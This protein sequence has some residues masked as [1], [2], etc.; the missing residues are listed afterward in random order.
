M[1][2]GAIVQIWYGQLE[3]K[4]SVFSRVLQAHIVLVEDISSKSKV[5][6]HVNYQLNEIVLSDDS[7]KA[8]SART[9]F[10]R[11]VYILIHLIWHLKFNNLCIEPLFVFTHL[12]TNI[13]L[14][15]YEK[16]RVCVTRISFAFLYA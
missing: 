9:Y 3:D 4:T 8:R 7:R 10:G 1:R 2:G 13:N 11:R 16:S 6:S 12:G 15:R 14:L 5:E